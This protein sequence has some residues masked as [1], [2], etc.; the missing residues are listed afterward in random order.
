MGAAIPLIR[1]GRMSRLDKSEGS[2]NPGSLEGTHPD[3]RPMDTQRWILRTIDAWP[4]QA[5]FC[6]L[7]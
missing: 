2:I 1:E 5:R 6:V 3:T 4:T 7:A